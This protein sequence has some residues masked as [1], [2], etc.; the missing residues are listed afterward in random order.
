M[1]YDKLIFPKRAL[2]VILLSMLSMGSLSVE[3]ARKKPVQ[4]IKVTSVSRVLPC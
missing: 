2:T 1:L 3:A 4:K